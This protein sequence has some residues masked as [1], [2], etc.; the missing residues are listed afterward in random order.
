MKVAG[1][2]RFSPATR[3]HLSAELIL[4]EEAFLA[5]NSP[6]HQAPIVD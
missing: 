1:E 6:N 5:K 4:L 3:K 2:A